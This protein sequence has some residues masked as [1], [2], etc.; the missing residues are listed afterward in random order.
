[1]GTE[2]R[3]G[4]LLLTGETIGGIRDGFRLSRRRFG[5]L[6]GVHETTVLRWEQRGDRDVR[7]G[8]FHRGLLHLFELARQKCAELPEHIDEGFIVGGPLRALYAIFR[9]VYALEP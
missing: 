1:M 5:Q 8:D 4:K 2:A 9:V 7:L 6:L 3:D